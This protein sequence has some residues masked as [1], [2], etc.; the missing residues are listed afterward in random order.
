MEGCWS[1]SQQSVGERQENSLVTTPLQYTKEPPVRL[2]CLSMNC[3]RKP[4]FLE[5]THIESGRKGEPETLCR[6][7]PSTKPKCSPPHNH[8]QMHNPARRALQ[9][10]AHDCRW[11][12]LW[13][14]RRCGLMHESFKSLSLTNKQNHTPLLHA[15]H[16]R[17]KR[18]GFTRRFFSHLT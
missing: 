12:L 11:S 17:C 15:P 8:A 5:K 4:S 18:G 16:K 14:F 7:T 9:R 2:T 13:N 10:S 6:M 1:L 3:G